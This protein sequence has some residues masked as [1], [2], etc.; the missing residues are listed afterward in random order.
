MANESKKPVLVVVGVGGMGQAI[1][2]RLGAGKAVMVADFNETTLNSVVTDLAGDGYQVTGQVVDVSDPASVDALVAAAQ[3]LG[4][5]TQ[6]AHTAG[7]SPVQAPGAAIVAVDLVGVALVL[8]RFGK[9]MHPGGAGVVIASMAAQMSTVRP[10]RLTPEQEAELATTPAEELA[11]LPIVETMRADGATAYGFAK[12][13]NQVRVEAQ[14]KVWGE[15]GARVNSISPGIIATPMGQQELAGESGALMRGMIEGSGTG[16]IGTPQDIAA[17]A[18]FL[19]GPD[20]SFI[21]GTDLLVDGG[22]V[23]SV[24]RR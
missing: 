4:P 19:L 12:R 13:A 8:D 11:G 18:D 6:L 5:I 16:R 7:L 24:R 15:R 20:A 17:A 23:A 2:R 14:A 1:A 9:V 21:T 3:E 22:V 10:D